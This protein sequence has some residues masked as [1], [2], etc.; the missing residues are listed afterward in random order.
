PKFEVPSPESKYRLGRSAVLRCTVT[1]I[2]GRTVA[3]LDQ[4]GNVISLR[5]K[6][7][8]GDQRLRIVHTAREEWSLQIKK[9]RDEDFGRYTCL[10]NSNPVISRSVLLKNTGPS[11]S[12]PFLNLPKKKYEK[13]EGESVDL[14]CL[15]QGFPIPVVT[16]YRRIQVGNRRRKEVLSHKGMILKLTDIKPGDSGD[17]YCTGKNGVQPLSRGKIKLNVEAGARVKLVVDR[18]G[19]RKGRDAYLECMGI[20]IPYPTVY[21]K[22]HKSIIHNDFQHITSHTKHN[23]Y[24][25]HS[26][27]HI[28]YVGTS[29]YGVYE[30][31]ATNSLGSDVA[32]V[33]LYGKQWVYPRLSCNEI[34]FKFTC[35]IQHC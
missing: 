13:K 4:K 3:W 17:Y 7:I 26:K 5:K 25:S 16:W 10:V 33:E 34:Q 6:V 32:I 27:L 12:P 28:R 11:L 24:T 1:N 30:C 18:I 23:E 21:W 22:R 31:V 9:L 14:E 35:T 20:G 19:Q 15:F 2:G 29:N 8:N